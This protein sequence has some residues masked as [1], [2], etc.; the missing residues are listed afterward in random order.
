MQGKVLIVE[1]VQ[2]MAD[3]ISLY[4]ANE[5]LQTKCAASAEHAFEILSSWT[6]DLIILDIN[7]PGM[8]GFEFL[9]RYRRA[10]N[11]PVMVVSARTA[12]ED[13]ISSLGC[14]A[15]EFMTKPFSPKVL[16][17]RVRAL[18]RRVRDDRESGNR[19]FRFGPFVLDYDS[20]ILKKDGQRI[21]LSAKEYGV[22]AWLAEHPSKPANPQQ[23]YESVWKNNY[24][25][26]SVV[27]VYIQRLRKKL[28]DDPTN[29]DYIETLRGIG[30]RLNPE[31]KGVSRP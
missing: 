16:A 5:G 31:G 3:L 30:Y 17:A 11:T 12:D 23:I 22:L 9:G 4:L 19:V 21:G 2:E 29:P 25:D 26:L 14:G 20:C 13:I 27:A 24:G 1:D 7:L 28:G 8:D 10:A 18:L 6:V 15:D